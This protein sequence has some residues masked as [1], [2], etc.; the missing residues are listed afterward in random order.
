[1]QLKNY[2][3]LGLLGVTLLSS[4]GKEQDLKGKKE[5]LSTGK[6]TTFTASISE[7]ETFDLL[8]YGADEHEARASITSQGYA[9]PK[10][11]VS[12]AELQDGSTQAHWGVLGDNQTP[13]EKSVPQ[14]NITTTKPTSM[15]TESTLFFKQSTN[16][17]KKNEFNF[18]CP[19]SDELNDPIFSPIDEKWAYFALGG[20]RSNDKRYLQFRGA[21]SPN[22]K[23]VGIKNMEEQ[24]AR[25]LPLMTDVMPFNKILGDGKSKVKLKARGCL[26]G[27]CFVNKFR[28]PIT[29]TEITVAKDNAL[30]FEGEFDM[31]NSSGN[32]TIN[33]KTS[34]QSGNNKE[35]KF[36]GDNQ[37]F[38][39]P[40]YNGTTKG[41][42]L[43]PVIGTFASKKANLPLFHL[44]GMPKTEGCWDRLLFQVKFKKGGVNFTSR[45]FTV[46]LPDNDPFKEGKSYRLPIVLDNTS[47]TVGAGAFTNNHNPLDFVAKY[48]V[49]KDGTDL[50]NHHTLP[51]TNVYADWCYYNAGL[52][53]WDEANALFNAG[54]PLS[55]A[56]LVLPTKEQWQSIIPTYVYFNSDEPEPHP[57][58]AGF[59]IG[60]YTVPPGT[61]S[62]FISK[63]EGSSFVTYALRFKGT[64]WE[65]A[66]RYSWEDTKKVMII[67]CVG[68]LQ[69]SG[70]TLASIS[71]P[72]FFS[73]N[74]ATTKRVFSAYGSS[75][76]SL[77][78]VLFLG[79]SGSRWSSTP[80]LSNHAWGID[81]GRSRTR[82]NAYQYTNHETTAVRPF[83]KTLN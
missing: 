66:W 26:I 23:I 39:Y 24:I 73:S 64:P 31:Q 3:A 74:P 59:V 37:S 17:Q 52:F 70:K 46:T 50:V 28:T 18:Y 43:L 61:T 22:Q 8:E 82:T 65:S 34:T 69:N 6:T 63:A 32:T 7:V 27:L 29:V 76:S 56:G 47:I 30:Y 25:Q 11:E 79:N 55:N 77:S 42:T 2:F 9:V 62:D 49:R 83:K 53:N 10:L 75:L 36:E 80:Y 81:F 40:I 60:T 13:D 51:T 4:C 57:S 44:W 14:A 68:G 12:L 15:P 58:E 48:D 72:E 71:Y 45:M 33:F 16:P 20:K 1:M 5:S 54:T 78:I 67:E 41:Y 19:V 38:I 21:T 35:T